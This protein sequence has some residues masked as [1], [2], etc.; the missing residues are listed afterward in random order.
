MRIE[1]AEAWDSLLL[2][3]VIRGSVLITQSILIKYIIL[4]SL[5]IVKN[6]S[7]MLLFQ[8]PEWSEDLTDWNRE[9]HV[10]WTYNGVQLSETEFPKNWLTDGIQIKILFPF[11]LKP[12]HRFKLQPSHKDPMKKKKGQKNDFFFLTVW[13]METELPFGSL[14]KRRSFFEP[15][16][17]ELKK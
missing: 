12:W 15:I 3:Q 5:I 17:K 4:P 14:R 8:F 10:K 2:A 9:M 16:F 1:I 11:C 6:I 13:G 7:R